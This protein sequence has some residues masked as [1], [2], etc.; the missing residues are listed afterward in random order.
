MR[1]CNVGVA[2]RWIR[3]FFGFKTKTTYLGQ[4]ATNKKPNKS[5]KIHIVVFNGDLKTRL[6]CLSKSRMIIVFRHSVCSLD[7]KRPLSEQCVLP[8]YDLSTL[9]VPYSP[10]NNVSRKTDEYCSVRVLDS[11]IDYV[12]EKPTTATTV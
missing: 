3:I 10:S 11:D 12:L 1:T 8:R 9:C 2:F 7:E 5:P 6:F 4:N